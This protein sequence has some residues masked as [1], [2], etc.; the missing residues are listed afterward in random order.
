MIYGSLLYAFCFMVRVKG[1]GFM[2][3]VY[4]SGFTNYGAG[5]MV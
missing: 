3:W 4:G 1:S 5:F 2:V